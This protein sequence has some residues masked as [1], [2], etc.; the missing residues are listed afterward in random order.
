M[1]DKVEMKRGGGEEREASLPG[2]REGERLLLEGSDPSW[3]LILSQRL[4]GE[5][6]PARLFPP[7]LGPNLGGLGHR[8]RCW[9]WVPEEL[10]GDALQLVESLN[11]SGVNEEE[12]LEALALSGPPPPQIKTPG[13]FQR[14]RFLLLSFF[15]LIVIPFLVI[16]FSARPR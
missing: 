2:Q 8:G 14:G 7:S 13:L 10:Y 15:L 1:S 16:Y 6:I 4:E 9:L 12:A 3:L 11:K 5:G